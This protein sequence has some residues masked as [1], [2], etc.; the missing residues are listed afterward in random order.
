MLCALLIGAAGPRGDAQPQSLVLAPASHA[1]RVFIDPDTGQFAEP[2]PNSL[3]PLSAPLL[4]QATA[5][6]TIV[7][8]ER[9]VARTGGGFS[10]TVGEQFRPQRGGR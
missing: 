7:V 4:A 10:I 9:A 1:L 5:P 8:T 6:R 2:S 3:E